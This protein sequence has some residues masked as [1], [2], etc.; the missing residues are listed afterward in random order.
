M[1]CDHHLISIQLVCFISKRNLY[2]LNSLLSLLLLSFVLI[3]VYGASIALMMALFF[4][5]AGWSYACVKEYEKEI[6]KMFRSEQQVSALQGFALQ[7]ERKNVLLNSC[8]KNATHV[9]GENI[10]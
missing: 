9:C 4:R 10:L 8:V 7:K 5:P 2:S 1:I 6:M 3:V